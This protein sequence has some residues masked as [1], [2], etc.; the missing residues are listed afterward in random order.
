MLPVR[1]G[2]WL[3]AK[4]TPIVYVSACSGFRAALPLVSCDNWL[5]V[6][7]GIEPLLYSAAVTPVRWHCS[8]V[9]VI[10]GA[11]G[12]LPTAASP[13]IGGVNSSATLGAR[14]A[15][16]YEARIPQTA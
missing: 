10:G 9:N 7:W 4:F 6:P 3:G 8:R 16:S 5:A 12:S 14:T 2:I 1:C 13:T 15:R 11:Q